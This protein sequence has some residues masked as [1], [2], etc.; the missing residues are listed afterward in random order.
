L[1]INGASLLATAET[2]GCDIFRRLLSE[3]PDLISDRQW[4]DVMRRK[5]T[6]A[7]IWVVGVGAL[8]AS[9]A[10]AQSAGNDSEIARLKQQLRLLEQKL[11]RLEKQSAA[12][13]KA[14][15]TAQAEAKAAVVNGMELY[16]M[17]QFVA[18]AV[19]RRLR[20]GEFAND[21]E[22]M[23]LKAS[24]LLKMWIR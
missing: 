3:C 16:Q 12:S 18:V 7:A 21:H 17:R 24:D 22:F 13:A 10:V 15:A 20:R 19:P 6:T 9:P 2:L 4:D 5:I 11:D 23:A 14:A 1:F 8:A